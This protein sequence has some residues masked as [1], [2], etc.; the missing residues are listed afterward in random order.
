MALRFRKSFEIL[1]GLR[2]NLNRRSVSLTGRIGPVSHTVSTS[3]R[4]T[5]S[6]NLPGPLSY[7]KETRRGRKQRKIDEL[8]ARRTAAL[9]RLAD[10]RRTR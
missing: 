6:V 2:L 1:P 8:E 4:D 7:R 10:R 5:T 9:A 3:G